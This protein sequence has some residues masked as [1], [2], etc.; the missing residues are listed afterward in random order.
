MSTLAP[1]P[2][3]APGGSAEG[4]GSITIPVGA[5]VVVLVALTLASGPL[6][7]DAAPVRPQFCAGAITDWASR[8]LPT[9][10]DATALTATHNAG[11][12]AWVTL[13]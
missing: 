10:L 8:L 2:R 12:L 4:G 11:Y 9:T 3:S 7:L 13:A 5:H 6:Y 1:A